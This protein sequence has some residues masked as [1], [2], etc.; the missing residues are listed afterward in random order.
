MKLPPVGAKLLPL[1][2]R[3]DRCDIFNSY[4]SHFANAPKK[5]A[6]ISRPAKFLAMAVDDWVQIVP[7]ATSWWLGL[8]LV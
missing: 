4:F 3:M 2:G 5:L 8:Q 7:M 1:G 6:S